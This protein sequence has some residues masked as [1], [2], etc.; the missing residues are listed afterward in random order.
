MYRTFNMG[1]GMVLVVQPEDV[2]DI[3]SRLHGLGE[4]AWLIGE[5]KGKGDAEP[6]VELV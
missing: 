6:C 3:I 4:K 2:E 1:I 5:I